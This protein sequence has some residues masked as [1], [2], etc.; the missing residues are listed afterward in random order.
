MPTIS[1]CNSGWRTQLSNGL[2][3]NALGVG[4]ASD[5]F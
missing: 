4:V 2:A 3:V 5:L 1:E